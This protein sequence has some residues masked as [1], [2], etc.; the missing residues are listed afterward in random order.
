M[1]LQ[2]FYRLSD[3]TNALTLN[4]QTLQIFIRKFWQEVYLPLNTQFTGNVHLLLIVKVQKNNGPDDVD[5]R[6][7][8]HQKMVNYQDLDLFTEYLINRVGLLSDSYTVENWDSLIFSYFIQTGKAPETRNLILNNDNK[9]PVFNN[10][11]SST[12]YG[13]NNYNLPIYLFPEDFG[14]IIDTIPK[15]LVITYY[16]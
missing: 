15:E 13:Y 10:K 16:V 6:S 12:I 3:G 5:F 11:Q 1:Q 4:P 9:N 7:L 8:A 14:V 2:K